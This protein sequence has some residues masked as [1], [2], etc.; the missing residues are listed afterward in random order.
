MGPRL[1]FR[2]PYRT[3]PGP[4]W[5]S[6][7]SI[8]PTEAILTN[9]SQFVAFQR[10]YKGKPFEWGDQSEDWSHRCSLAPMAS[11]R[12]HTVSAWAV[13]YTYRFLQ[14]GGHEIHRKPIDGQYV[15]DRGLDSVGVK[16]SLV[17]AAAPDR[18]PVSACGRVVVS[19]TRLVVFSG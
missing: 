3:L 14:S 16:P 18:L 4:I 15:C 11:P 12:A 10:V 7:T 13:G 6:E 8:G 17:T 19:C 1:A 5:G 9:Y 2:K